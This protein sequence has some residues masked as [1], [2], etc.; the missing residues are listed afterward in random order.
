MAHGSDAEIECQDGE[1]TS[2]RSLFGLLGPS[3]APALR[4][5]P[6]IFLVQ[7]CRVGEESALLLDPPATDR[8]GA[9]PLGDCAAPPAEE[10]PPAR[11]SELCDDH[12]FLWGYA[13]TAGGLAYRGAL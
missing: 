2:L 1:A 8:C 7:A 10:P 9:V 12:D 3:A 13:T 4:G 5:K 6:K 11:R